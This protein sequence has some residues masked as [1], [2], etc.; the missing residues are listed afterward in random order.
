MERYG[1]YAGNKVVMELDANG[2]HILPALPGQEDIENKALRYVLMHLGDA[3]QIEVKQEGDSWRVIVYGH[4]S[5]EVLGHLLYSSTGKLMIENS[6]PVLEMRQ[7]AIEDP[8]LKGDFYFEL[9]T[10]SQVWAKL[11]N[12]GLILWP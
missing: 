3:V 10:F 2:I 8:S 4:M 5:N 11:D 1:L 12:Q 7:K 9:S 6:T